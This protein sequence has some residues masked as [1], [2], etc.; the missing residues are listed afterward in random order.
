MI[1]RHILVE[2]ETPNIVIMGRLTEIE[3]ADINETDIVVVTITGG[4]ATEE[5][6]FMLVIWYS[7]NR[8]F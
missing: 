5:A 8:S 4:H 7:N 2:A 3:M 6:I 1:K